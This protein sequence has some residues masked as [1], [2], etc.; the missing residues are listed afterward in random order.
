M[1]ANGRHQGVRR[2][3]LHADRGLGAALRTL[4]AIRGLAIDPGAD[5]TTYEQAAGRLM[6]WVYVYHRTESW[7]VRPIALLDK[8][9]RDASGPDLLRI[10][11][12]NGDG[13][14]VN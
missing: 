3:L 1:P 6:I 10:V 9:K 8:L 7:P 12:P 11:Q 5:P 13:G 2:V 14:K 4:N